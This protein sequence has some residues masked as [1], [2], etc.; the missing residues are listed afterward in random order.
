MSHFID[1]ASGEFIPGLILVPLV[2]FAR[3][4]YFAGELDEAAE[5]C[6]SLL[7][8]VVAGLRCDPVSHSMASKILGMAKR[9]IGD[10]KEAEVHLAAAARVN[11]ASPVIGVEYDAAIEIARLRLLQDR[12]P[13]AEA[14]L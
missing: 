11:R 12:I 4:C 10:L 14:L 1:I 6:S 5:L 7:K 9:D 3:L 13:E 8:D 2:Y